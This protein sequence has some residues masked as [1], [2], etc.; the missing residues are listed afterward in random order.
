MKM[1]KFNKQ[2]VDKILGLLKSDTYTITEICRQAG[3]STRMYYKWLEKNPEFAEA[4]KAAQ[5]E[6]MQFFVQEAK[7]SLLKKIQ[8]YEVTETKV[9]TMP[10]GKKDENGKPVPVI[11]EQ[12]TVKKHIQPD[13]AAIIFT[14]TNGD[15][16][17]W[18][19]RRTT[20]VTGKGGKDLFSNKTDEDI[21]KEIA[22]LKRK[23]DE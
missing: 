22:E 19:N 18:Q 17:N 11:K 8:G 10:S 12:Q 20:E 15:P 16:E 9:V 13:T 14:L 1:A 3:V 23:L 21:D 2:T 6:R 5:D 4:V 7:K